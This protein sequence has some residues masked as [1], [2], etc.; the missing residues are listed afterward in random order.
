MAGLELES[1]HPKKS[2]SN[3]VRRPREDSVCGNRL[4]TQTLW[5]M[6]SRNVTPFL[7]MEFVLPDSGVC[8]GQMLELL[9]LSQNVEKNVST[10]LCCISSAQCPFLIK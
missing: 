4:T 2:G 5:E 8:L 1:R 6:V 3:R 10:A 9:R 7:C